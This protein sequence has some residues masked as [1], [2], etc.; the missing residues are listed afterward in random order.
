MVVSMKK[1]TFKR[2]ALGLLQHIIAAGILVAIAGIR[3]NSYLVVESMKESHTYWFSPLDTEPEFEDSAVF[4]DMVRTAASDVVE[5]VAVKGLMETAGEFDAAKKVNIVR[6]A[7]RSAG[8][9]WGNAGAVYELEDLI[10]W[11]RHGMEYTNRA[12]SI[13]DFVNYFG[14]AASAENFAL[15]ENGQL[16]F[17]GFLDSGFTPAIRRPDGDA[18]AKRSRY[19]DEER[20][21]LEQVMRQY[22]AGQLEDMAFSYIM[23]GQ[24]GEINVSRE[25]DGH[26]TIYISMLSCKYD[27]V[28]GEKQLTAYAGNWPD[29]MKL[30]NCLEDAI[31][32]LSEAYGVYQKGQELYEEGQG[33]FKFAIRMRDEMGIQHTYTN[34]SEV[35]KLSDSDLTEYFS[36]YRRYLVCYLE[37]LEFNSNTRL[38]ELDIYGYVNQYGDTYPEQSHIWMAVDTQY[39]VQGDVFYDAN[40]VFNRIVPNIYKLLAAILTLGLFWLCIAGYLFV[41]AGFAYHADGARV[42][43][44]NAF[45]HVWTECVVLLAA[46]LIYAGKWGVSMLGNVANTVY[47]SHSELLGMSE[48]KLYE[49]GTYGA[50]G[51]LASMGCSIVLFS[52]VRRI[53]AGSMVQGSFCLWF[54]RCARKGIHFLSSHR[55]MAV[56]TLIPYNLFLLFN[57]LAVIGGMYMK[58]SG[59]FRV[60]ILIFG[61]VLADGLIG[62]RLFKQNTERMD[63][64][65]GIRR[66]RDGEVDYKLNLDSLSGT[67]R[68]LADAVNNIGEGIRKAVDTSMKDEQMKS[69][70]ITNV[71]HDIKTPLTSI[72]NYVDL[73]KRLKIE[74]EPAKGYIEILDGKAQRLK[75]LTDDLLE[76][77]KISSG[78]IILNREKLNL[79]EL[80]KQTIGEFS[81]RLEERMLQM[82][83]EDDGIP[84]HIYADSRR[85]WRIMENL[86]YNICKYAMEN[87]RVHLTLSVEAETVRISIKNISRQPMNLRGDE[88]T[89]RFIRGDASR[90]TEG[91]G[92]GLFI[93]KSLTQAQGGTFEIQLDGDLFKVILS[94]PE[95]REG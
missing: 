85:M 27:T 66:I 32:T 78:N 24:D 28:D 60:A 90:T 9:A 95:Y 77:S 12:M 47:S 73:L 7:D 29:Y 70:L 10:K 30:Q 58:D 2:F 75:Q 92:L 94:F 38:T 14:P 46:A 43:Y 23:A 39:A 18:Q 16:Y 50:F 35:K 82:V 25:D 91:S 17:E 4:H 86:F 8:G 15:D 53:R 55:N 89:E 11:G 48:T 59:G 81:E 80:L 5:Y 1:P 93:A 22:S 41:T 62:V 56:N 67:S 68:E 83:F 3:F 71:S 20:S 34:L 84:A 76:A 37:N 49:Y 88:L 26:F 36:E 69:D 19:S 40:A 72:I 21:R 33:N 54:L 51:A 65:D 13:S 31:T 63:I 44:L 42:C 45:D 64:I 57:M 87:T 52:M 61:V 79:T 74:D 6:Y